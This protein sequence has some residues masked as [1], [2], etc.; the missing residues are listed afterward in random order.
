MLKTNGG[1]GHIHSL[2]KCD[3]CTKELKKKK[4]MLKPRLIGTELKGP[5][6]WHDRPHFM[7]ASFTS[8]E[9]CQEAEPL[10][11]G[12]SGEKNYIYALARIG[13]KQDSVENGGIYV[14]I[15]SGR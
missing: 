2:S 3:Y 11:L 7:Q 10:A 14:C 12:S 4:K 9:D 15:H 1:T 5:K 13:E 8:Y 6:K